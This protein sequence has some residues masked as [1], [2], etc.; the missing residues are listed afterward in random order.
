MF[1]KLDIEVFNGKG[2][3]MLWRKKMCVVLI[4]LNVAKTIDKSFASGTSY[5]K[6]IIILH[7]SN[8]V[9]R[10]V[11]SVKST[12]EIWLKLEEL[13]LTKSL[14]DSILMLEQ[15]FSFKIDA[16][17]NLDSNLNVLNR[18]PLNLANCKV[19]FSDEH[20][21]MI[22]FNSFSLLIVKLKLQ[23]WKR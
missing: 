19:S 22:L 13:Y 10:K 16:S 15:Y 7:I 11:D 12:A 5:D 9:L 3:F 2:D 17:R 14:I 6:S 1:T 23:L 4:Q 18:L 20:N 8:N 21:A